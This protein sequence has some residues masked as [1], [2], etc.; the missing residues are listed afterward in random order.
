MHDKTNEISE[1]NAEW[2]STYGVLTAERILERFNIRLSHD[3]L[4]KT[5]KNQDSHYHH[6]LTMPLK[7][8]F[9]GILVNQVHDY[10][11][12][13]QK[14]LIDY[15][16]SKTEP[17]V[18]EESEQKKGTHSEEALQTKQI[19]LMQ[20]G[21][22]FTAKKQEHRQLISDSQ[23][24]LIQQ[25]PKQENLAQATEMLTFSKHGDDLMLAFQQLRTE[26]RTL[27]IEITSLLAV[28]PNYYMDEEK[29]AKNHESLAFTDLT[30]TNQA[31]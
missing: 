12:Y 20:L 27:I 15:K 21:E 30:G 26:F 1:A 8:I 19:E 31:Q 7:N 5:L 14:L 9:N 2:L 29:L 24:W 16:L 18:S 22:M 23:A 17:V 10:Q 28:A 11:V 25:A 13:A 4:I 3:E 6:L